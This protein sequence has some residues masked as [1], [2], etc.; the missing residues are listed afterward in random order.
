MSALPSFFAQ[1]QEVVGRSLDGFVPAPPRPASPVIEAMRY[2]LLAPSK[3]VRAVLVMLAAELCGTSARAVPAA[4]AIEVVHAASLPLHD[5]P[6]MDNAQLRRGR[7][8][9]HVAFGEAVTI[10]AAFGLLNSAY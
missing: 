3:R 9:A 5:L 6:H 7:P 10:L 1:Y 4:C 8:S 2:T